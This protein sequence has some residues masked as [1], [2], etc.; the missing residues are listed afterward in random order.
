MM[1]ERAADPIRQKPVEPEVGQVWFWPTETNPRHVDEVVI[2]NS[3]GY[4]GVNV[5]ATTHYAANGVHLH[6]GRYMY[7]NRVVFEME[8]RWQYLGDLS[9]FLERSH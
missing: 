2:L 1:T 4:G 3:C 9:E 6:G 5:W 8:N 7:E